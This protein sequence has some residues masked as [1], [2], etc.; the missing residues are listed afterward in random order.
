[1]GTSY[2]AP[3]LP[4][5]AQAGTMELSDVYEY[6]PYSD[7]M[8]ELALYPV[9][10]MPVTDMDM[11]LLSSI[12][13][14][15]FLDHDACNSSPA[16]PIPEAHEAK[17]FDFSAV[18]SH[19]F[20]KGKSNYPRVFPSHDDKTC[21]TQNGSEMPL[22]PE[23]SGWGPTNAEPETW[24][25]YYKYNTTASSYHTPGYADHYPS[26]D[27]GN[28]VTPGRGS[29]VTIHLHNNL[30]AKTIPVRGL[31]DSGNQFGALISLNTALKLGYRPRDFN[32]GP[33]VLQSVGGHEHVTAGSIPIRYYLGDDSH[34]PHDANFHVLQV[35][36]GG[37]DVNLPTQ[38][39]V[40]DPGMIPVA[41]FLVTAK[42]EPTE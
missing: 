20:G 40:I 31:L 11:E 25:P 29:D 15:G 17:Y 16:I 21:R 24:N 30:S 2:I 26:T 7:D 6:A 32:G 14:N 4:G 12:T 8:D 18:S 3:D 42:R 36:A 38:G 1:M 19:T 33:R 37:Y 10:G 9:P 28:N 27:G 23:N 5:Q 35:L 13:A 39:V 41:A 22:F 34:N